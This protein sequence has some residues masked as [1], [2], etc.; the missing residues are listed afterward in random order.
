MP[1]RRSNIDPN[2]VSATQ[3]L[4][5]FW[6]EQIRILGR[7]VLFVETGF[8][9]ASLAPSTRSVVEGLLRELVTNPFSDRLVTSTYVIAEAIRR[10]VKSK[11]REFLGPGGEQRTD[12]AI[13]F[14]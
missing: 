1:R 3:E 8:V 10:I 12:L 9:L 11:P 7:S 4:T 2:A 14:L 13:Y 6:G 5:Q